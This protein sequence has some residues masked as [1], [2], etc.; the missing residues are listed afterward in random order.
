M[1]DFTSGSN[2]QPT[3]QKDVLKCFYSHFFFHSQILLKH[4]IMM[5]TR[6]MSQKYGKKGGQKNQQTTTI[7]LAVQPTSTQKNAGPYPGQE[8]AKVRLR[9][10]QHIHITTFNSLANHGGQYPVVFFTIYLLTTCK[11]ATSL[12]AGCQWVG[13]KNCSPYL[14]INHILTQ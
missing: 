1:P 8:E 6:A 4:L 11:Q 13:S 3:I 5:A 2:R 10:L 14:C 7:V 12:Q 9:R